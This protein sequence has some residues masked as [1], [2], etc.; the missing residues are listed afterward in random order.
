M[1]VGENQS[2]FDPLEPRPSEQELRSADPLPTRSEM[3][4]LLPLVYAELKRIAATLLERERSD[5]T[6][7]ATALVH[8]VYCK[9][10]GQRTHGWSDKTQFLQVA[11][12]AMRRLLVDH[13]RG[14]R[15][16][17]RG[18][19]PGEGV[20]THDA[21]DLLPTLQLFEERAIDLVALDEALEE[22]G[23]IDPQK[24][25][26]VEMRFFGGMTGQETAEA[27]G[28]SLRTVER[29]WAFARAW[30][31]SRIADRPVPGGAP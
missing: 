29:E 12:K 1:P 6:L 20:R 5:H 19:A 16:K 10:L 21:G 4:R 14:H 30:L 11:A 31:L 24:S 13:S 22:L 2:G 7:Q 23:T 17:K 28:I 27:M 9:L 8:E 25:R 15:A 18:G 3:D 26:I